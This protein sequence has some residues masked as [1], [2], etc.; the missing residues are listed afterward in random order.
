MTSKKKNQHD[1]DERTVKCPV[2]E[3]DAEPLARGV[4]L[5]VMRSSGN[6][7]G[8]NGEVPEH[9][10]LD[11][12]ES[13]GTRKVSMD[14]PEE[15]E[16]ESVM[17]LCPYCD[18]P[19]RGAHGVMIHLGQTEGRKNHPEGAAKRHELDDFP[20]VRLDEDENIVEYIEEGKSLNEVGTSRT[21]TEES[22]EKTKQYIE[23]LEAEGKTEEAEKARE[24]LL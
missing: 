17:R 14:Y 9:L 4:H 16:Q 23:Q 18:E 21:S 8:P 2:E 5:H 19:F 22:Q 13:V 15:R 24:M 3:C 20:I 1:N 11:N 7:H 6:G 12:L 10:D